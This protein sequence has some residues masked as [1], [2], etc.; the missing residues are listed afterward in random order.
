MSQTTTP[1]SPAH[2]ALALKDL[3]L[4]TLH[5]KAAELQNSIS[6]LLSSNS[7]LQ[8]LADEGDED[9]KEAV[10]ENEEVVARMRERVQL[11]KAEA[12]GRGLRWHMGEEEG[13]TEK[14]GEVNGTV[15]S[16]SLTDE[17]LRRRLEESLRDDEGVDG[18][19][20]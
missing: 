1:I 12:E 10:R 7:Q 16:G 2:F 18:V 3:P 14:K 8:P 4:D 5:T 17:E 19:H 13:E 9:C 6:H 20:L 11:C 15:A